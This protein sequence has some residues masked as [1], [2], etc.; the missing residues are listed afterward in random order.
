M[1]D[2]YKAI[3]GFADLQDGK[4]WYEAG[5][6]FPREGHKVSKARFAELSGRE[7]KSKRPLIEEIRDDVDRGVPAPEKLVQPKAKRGRPPKVEGDVHNSERELA[8]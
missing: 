2:M 1:A 5:D 6:V 4:H 8:E 3:S 7:N